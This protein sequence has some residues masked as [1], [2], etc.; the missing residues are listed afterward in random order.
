MAS[1]SCVPTQISLL[2]QRAADV[3]GGQSG[4]RSTSGAAV[5]RAVL[6]AVGLSGTAF[7]SLG[8]I[9]LDWT[10]VLVGGGGSASTLGWL[11]SGGRA[12]GGVAAMSPSSDD[13]DS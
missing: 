13:S 3:P 9:A 10:A 2:F 5:R 1:V 12:G 8:L 11:T 4:R 7:T 6:V